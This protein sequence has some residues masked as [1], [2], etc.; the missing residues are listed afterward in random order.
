MVIKG[1]I[2]D[3][4]LLE[5]DE[6][7]ENIKNETHPTWKWC[8]KYGNWY[9]YDPTYFY[10]TDMEIIPK[11]TDKIVP[12]PISSEPGDCRFMFVNCGKS[13]I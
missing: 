7:R 12:I 4:K 2:I 10:E 9:L 11:D 13:I 6:Y 3:T 8:K 1:K 5:N